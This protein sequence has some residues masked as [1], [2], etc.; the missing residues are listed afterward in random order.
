[1]QPQRAAARTMA[2]PS[3]AQPWML[4]FQRKIAQRL[5]MCCRW[6]SAKRVRW[7]GAARWGPPPRDFASRTARPKSSIV[8]PD[9]AC[10]RVAFE[11]LAPQAS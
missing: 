11:A 9:L 1:M 6:Q 8:A 5:L 4:E 3:V 7:L 2:P 10:R